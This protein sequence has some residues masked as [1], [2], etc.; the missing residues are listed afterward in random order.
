MR[1]EFGPFAR[2]RSKAACQSC[3]FCEIGA[4]KRHGSPCEPVNVQ[5]VLERDADA[6]DATELLDNLL[7]PQENRSRRL[8]Y[9]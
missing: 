1:F 8:T 5:A 7:Q 9:L 6:S 3:K 4:A 2:R